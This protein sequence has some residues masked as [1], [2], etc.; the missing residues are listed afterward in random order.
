[1]RQLLLISARLVEKLCCHIDTAGYTE[2]CGH[3]DTAD[4]KGQRST[5]IHLAVYHSLSIVESIS[6]KMSTRRKH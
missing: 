2:C 5:I 3:Q 1:M 6:E 4:G